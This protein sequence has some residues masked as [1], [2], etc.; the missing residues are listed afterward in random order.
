MS[1]PERFPPDDPRE[2]MNRARSNL[3]V[4]RNPIPG[5]YLEGLC[6]DAQQAAEEA[7]RIL[8]ATGS[9]VSQA[10]KSDTERST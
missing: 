9:V 4:A 10:K 5:A 3:L 2:W 8:L 7:R 6:F 1:L